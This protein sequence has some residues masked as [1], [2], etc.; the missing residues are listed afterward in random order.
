MPNIWWCNQGECWKCERKHSIVC[1]S[2]IAKNLTFRKTAGEVKQGD[3]IVHYVKTKKSI[4]A[5]SKAKEDAC[6]KQNIILEGCECDYKRAWTFKTEYYDLQKPIHKD[7]VKKQIYDLS[8]FKGPIV[9][10]LNVRRAYFMPFSRDGLEIIK[11]A[12]D[13]IF[14]DWV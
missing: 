10:G 5:I 8:L 7:K 6:E 2:M 12:T 9:S 13:E 3:L 4:V 1:S 14:P 11:N